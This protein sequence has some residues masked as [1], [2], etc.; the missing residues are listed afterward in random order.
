[1]MALVLGI[2]VALRTTP[3]MMRAALKFGILDRPD[4]ALKNHGEAVPY[5]GGLAVFLAFLFTLALTFDFSHKVLGI[6]LAGTLVL[7]VG[8]IDDLGVLTP[9]EKLTGQLVAVGVLL[10]AGIYIKLVFIP[11]PVALVLSVLWLLVITNAMNIIDVMDGLAS[12]IGVIASLF[13][14]VTALLNDEPMVAMMAMALAGSLIGFL[15]YNFAPARIYLGDSGSLFVGLTL[16]ALAMNGA[17]TKRNIL[18]MLTPVI[19]LGVPLF[20]LAFVSFVRW[21]KGLSP[22]RGSA[23]HFAL[24]LTR[25]GFTVPQ[26]VAIA[27][28]IGAALGLA[29]L[30]LMQAE[31][32]SGAGILLAGLS[33]ASLVLLLV[34]KRIG[35]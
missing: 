16:A 22:F 25:A 10:K 6:L 7:L 32:E 18:A 2:V 13:L 20:D 24:R 23:D 33:F 19:F 31:H 35:E 34:L 26:T 14:A 30:A 5:L 9:W 29:G 15:R 17:Y 4:G 12:G 11:W 27:Y 3:L 21:R 1:M 28:G 8:L